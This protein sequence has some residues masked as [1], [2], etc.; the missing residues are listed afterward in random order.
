[1]NQEKLLVIPDVHA[2]YHNKEAF[3]VVTKVGRDWKPDVVV[4]LG[5]FGDF[6]SVADYVRDPTRP[7]QLLDELNCANS[8]L[9]VVASFKA[10]KVHFIAGNHEDRLD[11]YI[12][13]HAPALFKNLSVRDS[14]KLRE[15][16]WHYTPYKQFLQIGK[17]LFTHDLGRAGKDA[18]PRAIS[19]AH[20]SVVIGHT[21]RLQYAIEG[22]ALGRPHLAF[23]PGWLG[24][25]HKADYMHALRANREW[26]HGVGIGRILK[27]GTVLMQ[28]A[29]ISRGSCLVDGRLYQI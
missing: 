27:D 18:V 1:V 21:H 5:D 16:K 20:A 6:Y 4:I 10:T 19:D 11:R 23:C 13:S 29:P 14:F 28:P 25:P 8:L 3:E 9:D 26:A 15:R 7:N 17:M 24:D 12:M 22:D 2:P